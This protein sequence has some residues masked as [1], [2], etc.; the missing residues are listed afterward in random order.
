MTM[1]A[2]NSNTT[3]EGDSLLSHLRRALDDGIFVKL[4]LSK[5]RGEEPDLKRIAGRL[6]VLRDQPHLAFVSHYATRDITRN[7]PLPEALEEVGRLLGTTFRSIHLLTTDEEIAAEYSRKGRCRIQ[8]RKGPPREVPDTAHNRAKRRLIEPGRPFLQDLGITDARGRILPSMSHKW[9]QINRFLELFDKALDGIGAEAGQPVRVVDFGAGKGYLTF[10]VHDYLRQV[11]GVDAQ[12]TGVELRPELVAF[13]NGVAQRRNCAGLVMHQGDVE[14]FPVP[15]TDVLI[16]LH[17][18]DTATDLA[19]F[20]GIRAGAKVLMASPCCHKEVRP[21]MAAPE[22]LRPMLRFGI[23]LER[24]AEMVT[25]TLRAL[26]LERSGYRVQV[27]EFISSEHTDKNKM[28]LATKRP[29][30]P[31]RD[32]VQP[33]ID[34][35]KAFYGIREQRLETLLDGE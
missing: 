1:C 20:T 33:R 11:L 30:P 23:H 18:C 28:L 4:V 15:E 35:L 8:R 13:C 5:Y 22:V 24:E 17:A 26:L 9:K 34:A 10:A 6:V 2:E 12:V 21:Q 31:P 27:I 14:H 3:A 16:A 32:A 7:A 25:D 19:L 29:S